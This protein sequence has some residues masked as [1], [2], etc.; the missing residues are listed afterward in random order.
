MYIGLSKGPLAV[1]Q[2][3][4]LADKLAF[5]SPFSM[6]C[7]ALMQQGRAC[8]CPN[9]MYQVLLTSH[10]KPVLRVGRGWVVVEVEGQ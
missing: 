4:S 9:L 2:D 10:G 6:A 8:S 1:N 3:L 7:S 5:Q